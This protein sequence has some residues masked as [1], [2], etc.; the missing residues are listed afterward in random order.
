M[1]NYLTFWFKFFFHYNLGILLYA[2]GFSLADVESEFKKAKIEPDI[3][4]KAPIE[5]IEVCICWK[6]TDIRKN[7]ILEIFNFILLSFS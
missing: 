3:I 2:I 1:I 4:D 6:Y 7:L 5:K